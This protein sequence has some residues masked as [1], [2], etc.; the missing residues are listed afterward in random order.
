MPKAKAAPSLAVKVAVWVRK[1]GPMAEVA[2]RKMAAI[3]DERRSLVKALAVWVTGD[4]PELRNQASSK[5]TS[6][7]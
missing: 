1:P 6:M 3:N 2:I 4:V 5:A 7:P